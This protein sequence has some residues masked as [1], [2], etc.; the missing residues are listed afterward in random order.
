VLW[1]ACSFALIAAESEVGAP[2]RDKPAVSGTQWQATSDNFVVRNLHRAQDARVV[3]D[4]CEQWRD[5]LHRYWCAAERP[6]W[7]TKCEVVVHSGSE[8]YLA[9]VGNGAVQTFG[10]SL[11]QFD[12][13]KQVARRVIDFRGD[14]SHGLAAVPHEMTHVVLADLLDGRQPPRWADEGM[15][16]LADT[17][18]KQLLHDRDLAQGL[19]SRAAFRVAELLS[20]DA[21]PH[22]SR[23]AAFYGQSASLTACLARRDDPAKFVEFLRRSLDAGYDKALH[24]V[25]HLDNVAALEQ[26]WHEQR[27]AWSAG[28]HGVQLALE[29]SATE[30]SRRAE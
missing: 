30:S 12:N 2:S 21:Y 11:I 15:A 5:R 16:I 28:F 1:I 17:R 20:M 25:Y 29:A 14:S 7:R 27:L 18:D 6:A 10:S 8:S 19:A 26:T 22:P 23:V 13:S 3:A 24:D 9:A 4:Y